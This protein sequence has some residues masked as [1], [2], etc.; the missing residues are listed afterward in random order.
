MGIK[1]LW[2][3]DQANDSFIDY[4]YNCGIDIEARFNV[5]DGIKEL[6]SSRVYDALI[7]DANC[8]SHNNGNS[9]PDITALGY[10]LSQINKNGLFVPWFV[11]SAGGFSGEESID[12]I[13][14][15][16][17]RNYDQKPWYKKPSE[18]DLLF[19]K[20]N[21]VANAGF[22]VKIRQQ[23]ADV[24]GVFGKDESDKR[25]IDLL[26][27][28]EEGVT[29]DPELLVK[30]RKMLEDIFQ[31]CYE[32][33]ATSVEPTKTNLSEISRD[34]CGRELFNL[35]PSYIQEA[36]RCS[37]ITTNPAA[38]TLTLDKVLMN[39]EA[40]YIIRSITYQI[41][42][43]INWCKTLPQTKHDIAELQLKII[44]QKRSKR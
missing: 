36:I 30:A 32:H 9:E 24:I 29:N 18:I 21:E 44:E 23:Y 5:D 25:L 22:S 34:M 14:K 13:V 33:G 3:D 43:L 20:I 28:V 7:L 31:Y 40:P 17:E 41:L 4:A 12:I 15:A 42:T 1:V 8:I 6:M 10:A 38:H 2:I 19:D 37:V 11:Y 26:T 16:Q 35:I 27:Q 39:N